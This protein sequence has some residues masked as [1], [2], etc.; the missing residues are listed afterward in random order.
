MFMTHPTFRVPQLAIMPL[1]PVKVLGTIETLKQSVQKELAVL[2]LA[3]LAGSVGMAWL[4]D[5]LPDQ[6]SWR[7][8]FPGST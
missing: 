2:R 6:L 7:I 5:C 3:L 1:A 4:R 8:S